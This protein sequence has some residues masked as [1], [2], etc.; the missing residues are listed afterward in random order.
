LVARSLKLKSAR[1]AKPTVWYESNWGAHYRLAGKKP[2]EPTRRPERDVGRHFDA[3]VYRRHTGIVLP[4]QRGAEAQ[5]P[6]SAPTHEWKV[7]VITPYRGEAVGMLER[8]T[9][10]VQAQRCAATHFVI[11]EDLPQLGPGAYD[12][13]IPFPLPPIADE[14]GNVSRGIGAILAFQL[15]F[16]AVAFLDADCWWAPDHLARQLDTLQAQPAD[17]VVGR[18]GPYPVTEGVVPAASQ[19]QAL[20][21]VANAALIASSAAFLGVRWAH[22]PES[23]SREHDEA[24]L[25]RAAA[26]G[27]VRIVSA[28]G[29]TAYRGSSQRPTSLRVGS[30]L[31]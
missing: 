14:R 22:L 1:L 24:L 5:A 2:V 23:P 28:P 8:C 20:D 21:D 17:M 31:S 7:A 27:R 30:C 25:L 16:D 29:V 4:V 26:S 12:G 9:R 11:G 19:P 13:V 10:S 3:E 15:G 6:R 18:V